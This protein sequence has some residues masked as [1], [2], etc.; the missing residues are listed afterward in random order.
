MC[1]VD[2]SETLINSE[3]LFL[4]VKGVNTCLRWPA[5][6]LQ[7]APFAAPADVLRDNLIPH[8]SE[9]LQKLS[10]PETLVQFVQL[11]LWVSASS[12]LNIMA[13]TL[14]DFSVSL[15]KRSIHLWQK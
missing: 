7:K 10:L 11:L 3:E 8:R 1:R 6:S 13:V 2:R 4:E 9:R 15:L 12:S 5:E 14:L